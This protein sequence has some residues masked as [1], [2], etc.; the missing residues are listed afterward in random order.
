MKRARLMLSFHEVAGYV[1]DC[2][3]LLM[4]LLHVPLAV[5]CG[6]ASVCFLEYG[7]KQNRV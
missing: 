5:F 4:D 3:I 6:G 1:T 2:F 7:G